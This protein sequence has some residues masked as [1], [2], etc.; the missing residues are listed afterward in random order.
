MAD[1][2]GCR[3]GLAA[4]LAE[5][6]SSKVTA[7]SKAMS[8]LREW[9]GSDSNLAALLSQGGESQSGVGGRGRVA[10]WRLWPNGG[11]ATQARARCSL[12]APPSPHCLPLMIMFL[13]RGRGGCEPGWQVPYL[14]HRFPTCFGPLGALSCTH[15]TS[16]HPHPRP[17]PASRQRSWTH[18][19]DALCDC[20]AAS[21]A[22]AGKPGPSPLRV[23]G[24]SKL[25]HW[26]LRKS[27]PAYLFVVC[28]QAPS[29]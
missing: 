28:A 14:V 20:V 7:R 25:R 21:S 13:I 24:F 4:V 16:L 11:V 27:T 8:Q 6:A 2:D 17:P 5:L 23:R 12:P 26:P 22:G 10:V 1:D 3:G 19:A 29:R 18:V 9:M 15:I